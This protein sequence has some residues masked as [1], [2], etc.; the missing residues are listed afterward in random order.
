MDWAPDCSQGGA[1][2][3]CTEDEGDVDLDERMI[4]EQ[5]RSSMNDGNRVEC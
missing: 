5:L 3:A 1:K 4:V 2:L